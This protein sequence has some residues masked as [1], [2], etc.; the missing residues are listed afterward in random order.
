MRGMSLRLD[1][2]R[3]PDPQG[4]WGRR[5]GIESLGT[6]LQRIQGAALALSCVPTSVLVAL[7]GHDPAGWFGAL[8]R[9]TGAGL[10]VMLGLSLL[11][12]VGGLLHELDTRGA[13]IASMLGLGGLAGVCIPMSVGDPAVGL[14]ALVWYAWVGLHTVLPRA[15]G[16]EAEPTHPRISG[17]VRLAERDLSLLA[18]A[19][20][21]MTLGHRLPFESWVAVTTLSVGLM[22]FGLSL[23]SEIDDWRGKPLQPGLW[24]GW[25]IMVP[26]LLVHG[27]NVEAV[28]QAMGL[29][30]AVVLVRRVLPKSRRQALLDYLYTQ[31][32]QLFCLSFAGLVMAG[33][34]ALSFPASSAAAQPLAP[35]DAFFTATSAVCVTGLVTID[36]AV[37]LSRVGQVIVLALIQ[38]GGL[39]I[40]TLSSFGAMLISRRL[41]LRHETALGVLVDQPK[42]SEVLRLVRFIVL[43]TFGIE[44]VGA[45]VLCTGFMREGLPFAVAMWKGTFH[46]VSSFCNAGFALQSNNL[47]S[48]QSQ[49]LILVPSA[50]LIMAGGIGFPV[51]SALGRWPFQR[52]RLGLYVRLS[53][54]MTALLVVG[55]TALILLLEWGNVLGGMPLGTKLLNSFYQSV[56]LRTAGFN[57]VPMEAFRPATVAV[58]ILWMFIGGNSG[59]TAGG[60]KLTTVAVL[61]LHIRSLLRGRERVQAY[62]RT[63][64]AAIVQRAAAVGVLFSVFVLGGHFLLLLT[65]PMAFDRLLFETV[66]AMGTVG[67]TL[68]VTSRLDGFGK[69][70]VMLLMYV[71]RVGPLTL[72]LT[73]SDERPPRAKMPAENV[74]VG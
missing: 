34:T 40:I 31:P 60:V 2:G 35:I 47:V 74:P 16:V 67:L 20:L 12:A 10:A 4:P 63:I 22:A 71:G 37:N 58:M 57:S 59:G 30:Q 1:P 14:P 38:T 55:G 18:V 70:V 5:G 52:Q 49:A 19:L 72:V 15:P 39:G 13:R 54:L 68:D 45:L 21:L 51:L 50:V 33:G 65:Q 8:R 62:S 24:L 44:A 73:M 17:Q 7:L 28:A 3:R 56:T 42:A 36:P 32:A 66:S 64:P 11:V 53:L 46:A 9:M 61:G 23:M 69:I 43:S 26:P 41:G 6:A 25:L 27:W 48:Y 29:R